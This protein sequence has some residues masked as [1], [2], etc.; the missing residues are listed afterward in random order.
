MR[1]IHGNKN[2]GNT[3]VEEI[4]ALAKAGYCEITKDDCYSFDA[5]ANRRIAFSVQLLGII[6]EA[7]TISLVTED[8]KAEELNFNYMFL[9]KN[10]IDLERVHITN[11]DSMSISLESI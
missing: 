9:D 7:K 5:K 6:F 8:P 11:L 1:H 10:S 3:I 4:R 2:A